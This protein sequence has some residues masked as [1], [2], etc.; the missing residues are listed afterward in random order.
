MILNYATY[1]QIGVNTSNL[2]GLIHVDGKK[3]N[4]K[5]GIPNSQETI[6]DFVV[7]K[8]GC[9]GVGNVNPKATVDITSSEHDATVTNGILVPRISGEMLHL[10]DNNNTYGVEQDGILVF[11]LQPPSVI[12]RVGQT[13]DIDARG[14]YYFDY[15]IDKWV[16][17]LYSAKPAIVSVI[18]CAGARANGG[19]VYGFP[20][21]TSVTLPYKGGNG[22]AYSSFVINSTGV[23]G[24]TASLSPGTLEN[25]DGVVTF[26]I[27]GTPAGVGT[28]SFDLYLGGKNCSFSIPVTNSTSFV[29]CSIK[30]SGNMTI[31]TNYVAGSVKQTVRLDV[32]TLGTYNISAVKNGVTFAAS[33]TFS[34]VGSKDVDLIAT[35]IPTSS[36][37][38]TFPVNMTGSAG[39]SNCS[40]TFYVT[41][42]TVSG[43]LA[44][45]SGDGCLGGGQGEQDSKNFGWEDTG[46]NN[47]ILSGGNYDLSTSA[48]ITGRGYVYSGNPTKHV[49]GSVIYRL[50]N[51]QTGANYAVSKSTSGRVESGCY[52]RG[53]GIAPI[54]ELILAIAI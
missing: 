41:P 15:F 8:D 20:V 25:G 17:M 34:S 16:K 36:G 52:S 50:V 18:D 2:Q 53:G 6:N 14:F 43:N 24:L 37:L 10:A 28:A 23:T 5:S 44:S 19:I 54:M 31:N 21:N 22:G 47:I 12:N 42:L 35:G 1:A 46:I 51:V 40:F 7:T 30:S 32:T 27:E 26:R 38:I 33:G 45:R 48:N 29:N 9:L 3:D 11:V 39:V 13:I 49:G 4:P